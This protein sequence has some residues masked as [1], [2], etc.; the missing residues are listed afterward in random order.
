M[1]ADEMFEKFTKEFLEKFLEKNPDFATYLGLHEPYDYML[2][3]GST[4]RFLEN[5][6]M[7]EEGLTRLKETLNPAELSEDHKIDWEV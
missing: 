3:K 7:M 6:K 1:S 5:L 2:P 4:G